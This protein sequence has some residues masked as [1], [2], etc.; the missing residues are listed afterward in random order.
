MDWHAQLLSRE[1][2][3]KPQLNTRTLEYNDHSL[4]VAV[5]LANYPN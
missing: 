4:I 1:C 3:A 2:H 5:E